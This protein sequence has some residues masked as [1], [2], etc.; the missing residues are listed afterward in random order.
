MCVCV[1]VVHGS[2]L[3]PAAPQHSP[4]DTNHNL[5]APL[6]PSVTVMHT[7][8]PQKHFHWYAPSLSHT[9]THTHTHTLSFTHSHTHR[10][11]LSLSHTHTH[12]HTHTH[13]HTLRLILT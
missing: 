3:T 2:Q 12:T 6:L 10:H 11:T 13:R 1:C 8:G 5:L 7:H 9:H 4:A